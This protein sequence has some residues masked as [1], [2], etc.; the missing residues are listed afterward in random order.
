MPIHNG[1]LLDH[2]ARRYRRGFWRQL[3]A[4]VLIHILWLAAT[5]GALWLAL[6]VLLPFFS[7]RGANALVTGLY[8][9]AGT[10]VA[11]VLLWLLRRVFLIAA[12]CA[13]GRRFH[14]LPVLTAGLAEMLCDC[15]LYG[16][17]ALVLYKTVGLGSV[18]AAV[19]NPSAASLLWLLPCGA[20]VFL[21]LSVKQLVIPVAMKERKHFHAAVAHALKRACT[22][23]MFPRLLMV[24]AFQAVYAMLAIGAGYLLTSSLFGTPAFFNSIPYSQYIAPFWHLGIAYLL[25][26]PLSPLYSA[27]HAACADAAFGDVPAPVGSVGFGARAAAFLLDLAIFAAVLLLLVALVLL[28]V[29]GGNLGALSVFFTGASKIVLPAALML[30]VCMLCAAVEAATGGQTIGK[31]LLGIRA[32]SQDKKPLRLEQVLL[33]GLLRPVDLLLIGPCLLFFGKDKTRLGDIA[34]KTRV[35]FKAK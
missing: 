4:D 20:I 15:I 1:A 26:I 5:G 7:A 8:V 31:R 22:K 32:V 23:R 21:W 30:C 16:L 18:L 28:P 34:A 11:C 27:M 17:L 35:A 25:T 2:A 19:T 24:Q 12:A 3:I 13:G 6:S 9:L 29:T 14:V 33:R 10:G